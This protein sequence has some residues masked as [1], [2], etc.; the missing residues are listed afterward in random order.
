LKVFL[1]IKKRPFYFASPSFNTMKK[2]TVLV[3]D[4]CGIDLPVTIRDDR[5][6]YSFKTPKGWG[7]RHFYHFANYVDAAFAEQFPELELEIR[8]RIRG[9]FTT[10]TATFK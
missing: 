9:E 6:G 5:E 2:E 3:K 7:G 1:V 8:L 10:Q 4:V